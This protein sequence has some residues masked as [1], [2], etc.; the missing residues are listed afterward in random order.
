MR[1][2]LAAALFCAASTLCSAQQGAYRFEITAVGD[3]TISFRVQ[4]AGWMKPGRKGI[5][6]DPTRRDELIARFTVL[7]VEGQLATAVVTGQTAKITT[8]F[9]ALVEPPGRHWYEQPAVWIAAG[10]G[11]VAGVLIAR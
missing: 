8:S 5:A 3:S 7:R 4:D 1:A 2:F 11:I 6:V 10:A 9:V